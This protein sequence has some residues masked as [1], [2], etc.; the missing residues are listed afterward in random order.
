MTSV[1]TLVLNVTSRGLSATLTSM[2]SLDSSLARVVGRAVGITALVSG[3]GLLG[4]EL[5]KATAAY[6]DYIAALQVS[7][8]SQEEAL[9]A[10]QALSD[11]AYR[12]PYDIDEVTK[13]FIKLTNFG[14]SPSLRALTAY[15]NIAS[16][17][18]GKSLDDVVMAVERTTMGDTRRLKAFGIGAKQSADFITFTFQGVSTKVKK[19][20]EEIQRYIQ[21]IGEGPFAGG[22]DLKMY[23]L[24]GAM[25]NLR[26]SWFRL[27]TAIQLWNGTGDS[28]TQTFLNVTE[29]VEGAK[30]SIE[31]G[32]FEVLIEAQR[33]AWSGLGK[34]A[35]ESFSV[36]ST[37][38]AFSV[39][40][41]ETYLGVSEGAVKDSFKHWPIYLNT[42]LKTMIASLTDYVVNSK[43]VL[44]TSRDLG[45]IESN[46]LASQ[47][48]LY[49]REKS[50]FVAAA[51]GSSFRDRAAEIDRIAADSSKKRLQQNSSEQAQEKL[52]FDQDM[53]NIED[54]TDADTKAFDKKLEEARLLRAEYDLVTKLRQEKDKRVDPTAKYEKKNDNAA[55]SEDVT[56]AR[57]GRARQDRG[58]NAELSDLES[59]MVVKQNAVEEKV[60]ANSYE[61]R[62]KTIL[63]NVA[64]T[65]EE[66][67]HLIFEALSQ[68][69]LTETDAVKQ[70]YEDRARFILSDTQA[71]EEQKAAQIIRITEAKDAKLREIDKRLMAERLD[72]AA[73]FFGDLASIGSTFG[74]RGF[75]IA[76]GASIAQA[77]I[78]T[79]EAA[80]SAYA[81]LAGIPYVG[82]ALGAAAAAAAIVAGAANIAQ[83]K[84]QQYSGAY[85]DGGMIPAG[86]Y[87]L[88]GEAGPEIVRG[89]A[90]VTS[91]A[92]TR[93]TNTSSPSNVSIHNYGAP[94]SAT[95]EGSGDNLLVILRPLLAENKAATKREITSEIH[96]GG[97]PI[98]TKLETTYG[99]NRRGV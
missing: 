19:N 29:A 66:K 16:A 59:G 33:I 11:F 28:I 30:A 87:G 34:T 46:R 82:P 47:A 7:T 25:S 41:W 4:K 40:E 54:Q 62:K 10:Y 18:I 27:L 12:T 56:K 14:L 88:V 2:N 90:I 95:T 32:Q 17:T 69:L 9:K 70:A 5:I 92:A 24:S 77:T 45:K 74:E 97:S 68:S 98:A 78:K 26:D 20:A 61:A 51:D 37:D 49:L 83:I 50:G 58:F 65:E 23:R 42:A 76:K 81:S 36:I 73:K 15:G 21:S 38:F 96:R 43:N 39:K 44:S 3:I 72:A 67:K 48:G 31:S 6:G 80:T 79:Y 52:A 84:S 91:A 13:S 93:G 86:K 89:P 63:D 35:A 71:T 94:V 60:I 22:M 1:E 64:T 85:A 57:T 75:Q 55:L 8:G 99:L 53:K